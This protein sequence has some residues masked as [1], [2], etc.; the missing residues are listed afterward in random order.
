L[1]LSVIAEGV[2]T[3]E[4]LAFLFAHDCDEMQG[5]LFSRPLPADAFAALLREGHALALPRPEET[6]PFRG[7]ATLARL[8]QAGHRD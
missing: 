4:Q 3:R 5:Y 8:D 1:G 6:E 2:E 7:E